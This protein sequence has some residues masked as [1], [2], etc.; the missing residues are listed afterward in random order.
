MRCCAGR[1]ARSPMPWR[2]LQLASNLF[3]PAGAVGK[4]FA[5]LPIMSQTN[6]ADRLVEAPLISR[7]AAASRHFAAPPLRRAPHLDRSKVARRTS[8]VAQPSASRRG[9]RSM[10][11]ATY[12]VAQGTQSWATFHPALGRH[13]AAT[14]TAQNIETPAHF[15]AKYRGGSETLYLWQRVWRETWL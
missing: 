8:Q 4:A 3:Q 7:Q 5:S 15:P 9:A 14:T 12:P 11:Q 13:A 6:T 2:A 10:A 1:Q